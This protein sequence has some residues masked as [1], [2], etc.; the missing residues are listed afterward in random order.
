M[1]WLSTPSWWRVS[2]RGLKDNKIVLGRAG[3]IA[4]LYTLMYTMPGVLRKWERVIFNKAHLLEKPNG[5]LLKILEIY[6]QRGYKPGLM[7]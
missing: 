7:L 1:A 3:F 6:L 5:V 4:L 2:S